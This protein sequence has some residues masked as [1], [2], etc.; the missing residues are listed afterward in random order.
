MGEPLMR[1]ES[2]ND[3]GLA[4][5]ASR[6]ERALVALEGRLGRQDRPAVPQ[7]ALALELEAAHQRRRDLESAAAAA[8]K[9]LG[10]AMVEVRRTLQEDDDVQDEL[11][12]GLGALDLP[13]KSVQDSIDDDEAD[14]LDPDASSKKEPTA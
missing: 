1:G 6:L 7:N 2:V 3:G 8:S 10:R 13:A 9:A 12:L 14:G 5:S 4:D 11:P